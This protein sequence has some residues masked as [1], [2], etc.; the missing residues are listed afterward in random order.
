MVL[1]E[2]EFV[3]LLN[4]ASHCQTVGFVSWVIKASKDF[5]LSAITSSNIEHLDINSTGWSGISDSPS[6]KDRFSVLINA[7]NNWQPLRNSIKRIDV[8]G[9]DFLTSEAQEV[10]AEY[11]LEDIKVEGDNS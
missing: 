6:M 4:A 5:E 9:V 7:I 2:S 8:F 1:K 10:M 3:G 11:G